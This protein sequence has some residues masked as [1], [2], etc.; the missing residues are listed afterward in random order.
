MI[1]FATCMG[2]RY[3]SKLLPSPQQ[4]ASMRLMKLFG[5]RA[6]SPVLW[7]VNRRSVSKA[8]FIGSFF[9]LLP[10][11]FHSLFILLAVL[12]LQINLPIALALAWLCNPLTLV[13][14]IYTGFWIGTGIF[15]IPMVTKTI[16]LEQMHQ[17]VDWLTTLGSSP[18]DLS[19]AIPLLTGLLIEALLLASLL[20]FMIQFI[21]QRRILRRWQ[22]RH[23]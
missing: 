16:L 3:L 4:I 23:L 22:G 9:G 20:F 1:K 6:S 18:L 10:I 17:L 5:Q 21:W 11:P 2:K 7:Y 12:Y 14:I 15:R 19:L 13:P 8:I